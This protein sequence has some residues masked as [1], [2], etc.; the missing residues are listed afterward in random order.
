MSK[1]GFFI[2]NQDNVVFKNIKVNLKK[3]DVSHPNHPSNPESPNY[4]RAKE[5]FPE[6]QNPILGDPGKGRIGRWQEIK[7]DALEN[8][9]E[10][11]IE[12]FLRD[13]EWYKTVRCR[14]ALWNM[15]RRI[16]WWVD[17]QVDPH[18]SEYQRVLNMIKDCIAK[19]L[20]P[21]QMENVT[22]VGSDLMD[23]FELS[24][25][26]EVE[27]S[28]FTADISGNSIETIRYAHAFLYDGYVSFK[29]ASNLSEGA[30]VYLKVDGQEVWSYNK[31]NG[32][33]MSFTDIRYNVKAGLHDFEWGVVNVGGRSVARFDEI[34]VVELVN[35][36]PEKAELLPYCP[37]P[38]YHNFNADY[39]NHFDGQD[40]E[41]VTFSTAYFP[42]L[43]DFPGYF[44]WVSSSEEQEWVLVHSVGGNEAQ[45]DEN[46]LK[47]DLR[48]LK[49]G[50]QSKIT[51]YWRFKQRGYIRFKYLA[52]ADSGNDLFFFINGVQVG[53]GWSKQS[54]WKTVTFN[55]IPGQTYKFDWLVIKRST[56]EWGHNAIYIKDIECVEVI[57][58]L[59]L[60]VPP[61][62]DTLG[63]DALKDLKYEWV[64]KSKH[65]VI[66]TG[67]HGE[68]LVEDGKVR[69]LEIELD[70]E[71]D[72]EF[73]FGYNLKTED[74][75]NKIDWELFFDDEFGDKSQ[76]G[77]GKHGSKVISSHGDGWVLN[78]EYSSTDKDKAK[79]VYNIE[80]GKDAKVDI[81][82]VVELVSPERQI[83]H[84]Q[85]QVVDYGKNLKFSMSGDLRWRQN[86]NVIEIYD[87][88]EGVGDASTTVTLPEDGYFEFSFEH[89]L[90]PS[91]YFEVLVDGE[92]V[93]YSGGVRTGERIRIPLEKG[94]HI[95]TF[96]VV[97]DYTEEPL[98]EEFE[99]VYDY[100]FKKRKTYN[101]R[102]Q[103]GSEVNLTWYW[104]I[105]KG[106]AV[107]EDDGQE[108]IYDVYL[109]PGAEFSLT[110]KLSFMASPSSVKEEVIFYDDFNRVDGCD[111]RLTLIG[112]WE[113][114]D[115]YYRVH[116]YTPKPGQ[117][118]DGVW[119]VE[120]KDGTIN[121]IEMDPFTLDAGGY[122]EFE[123]GGKF[124]PYEYLE[125]WDNG[126]LIWSGREPSNDDGTGNIV[127]V[128]LSAGR[129][130][131]V[132]VYRDL[133]GTEYEIPSNEESSG[134]SSAPV[135]EE[136][137]G[138]GSDKKFIDYSLKSSS[139]STTRKN[140]MGWGGKIDKIKVYSWNGVGI[141]HGATENGAVIEREVTATSYSEIAYSEVLKVYPG[142][143]K[144]VSGIKEYDF[145]L[146]GDVYSRNIDGKTYYT[147]PRLLLHKQIPNSSV[148]SVVY[149]PIKV[150]GEV[151]ISFDYFAYFREYDAGP[152]N[153][154]GRYYNGPRGS[155]GFY[156][157]PKSV[158]SHSFN[159]FDLSKYA[160]YCKLSTSENTFA[161]RVEHL[162]VDN[163]LVV[164]GYKSFSLTFKG[165]GE[166]YLVWAVK[167][168]FPDSDYTIRSDLKY[169]YGVV[170]R[171]ISI[172]AYQNY[173]EEMD[174]TYVKVELID[175]STN[176]V[177]FSKNYYGNP[178]IANY[179]NVQFVW[180]GSI[181][182]TV[183]R[184]DFGIP[185]GKSYKIRYTL[186]KDT[187]TSGG[188][189]G[190]SGFT[191][192]EG[193]FYE[194][195]NGYCTDKNGNYYPADQSPYKLPS[196]PKTKTVSILPDDSW[197]WIDT[198]KVV[199]YI[200]HVDPDTKVLVR[201]YEGD[202]LIDEYVYYDR[203]EQEI[204]ISLWN[205]SYEVK[206]YR[207][208]IVF[209]SG[210]SG[211][212]AYLTEGRFVIYDVLDA[213]PSYV[214]IWFDKVV[215]LIPQWMGG[216]NGSK[217]K[218]SLYNEA[219][220][221]IYYNEFDQEGLHEFV[222][223]DLP[224]LPYS[225]YRV[226][227]ETEQRGIISPV[228]GKKY[229]TQFRVR[230]F[231]TYEEYE[232][233]AS[234]FNSVLEFY[235]DGVLIAV[236]DKEGYGEFSYKIPK[237]KHKFTWIFRALGDNQWDVAEIDWIRLL[238]WIC[239]KILVIPYCEPGNG[240]KCVEALISCLLSI[241]RKRPK[242][243]TIGKRIWLFT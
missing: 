45:G 230:E 11:I 26:W 67:I 39:F 169:Y 75:V 188:L 146:Y 81:N 177:I 191:L 232:Y 148:V 115:I 105:E 196:Q 87:L 162:R 205:D 34:R 214:Q 88:F 84:Y 153:K 201:V 178:V 216:W 97:D 111:P 20:D 27:E 221:L 175:K 38:Y 195:W 207:I 141:A 72:G 64:T 32:G 132:W 163:F 166:Y 202:E 86:G 225:K 209:K 120:G 231:K 104:D 170:L 37:A 15:Y 66:T 102:T 110:E 48:K 130:N 199:N 93:F 143:N 28:L 35:L 78:G 229:Y 9:V 136:C 50:N 29:F 70:N 173:E 200:S 2:E 16:K 8:V 133:G 54:D 226:E 53:G 52:S 5:R 142:L 234:P 157:I 187:G 74:P 158:V 71:C 239:D 6:Y 33:D 197:V 134:S 100:K 180:N 242:V 174:E 62:Y 235:I 61:D 210:R 228:T 151:K 227:I 40:V 126:Q 185:A 193:I 41:R 99:K 238:N 91:E 190:T 43:Q 150:N 156:I 107:A 138:P 31:P 149:S 144:P 55:V 203:G 96:R 160:N 119:K 147:S 47:L 140:K 73:S 57:K 30:K 116:S 123:Y 79:V 137:Y 77:V 224:A 51:F 109:N 124:A 139:I 128:F 182:A 179:Q 220:N 159:S 233:F 176:Q 90:K 76:E 10:Q 222:V 95:I 83:D 131:L 46:I 241:L 168:L 114:E 58:S 36:N 121:Y 204:N 198:I 68:H 56:L 85:E 113:W 161:G 44:R 65:S 117:V 122:V 218:V 3:D 92:S 24:D 211:D 42:K 192:S 243:C 12:Q 181:K 154:D 127:R 59:E 135:E 94:T 208:E 206:D 22:D 19:I 80:V 129:H 14:E 236:F 215:A 171:N 112:E 184:I 125:L 183:Y 167:D 18:K 101:Y 240:D 23:G 212:R 189:D 152:I 145:T 69:K 21:Q 25:G 219:N 237:G 164:S 217:I 108:V 49:F 186:Y 194:R 60:I 155:F 165:N 172:K 106:R 213:L 103:L 82:G 4:P 118:A 63:S 89:D 1:F 7:L 17:Q 223:T 98:E 13:R